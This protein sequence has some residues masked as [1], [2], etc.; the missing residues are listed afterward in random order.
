MQQPVTRRA[1]LAALGGVALAGCSFGDDSYWS[2]PPAFDDTGL[3][4]VT[5]RPRPDRQDPIPVSASKPCR[6]GR[7]VRK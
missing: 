7:Y 6:T 2:D 4:S 5:D 1:T 3:E